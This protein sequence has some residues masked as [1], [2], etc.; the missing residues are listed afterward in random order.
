[1]W[2]LDSDE[3]DAVVEAKVVKELLGMEKS[4][5]LR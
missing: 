5:H 3:G 4:L 2:L 1:M